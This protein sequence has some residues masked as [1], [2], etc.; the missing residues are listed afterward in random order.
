MKPSNEISYSL[1]TSCHDVHSN[2][3]SKLYY[4][5]QFPHYKFPVPTFRT[6]VVIADPFLDS[7]GSLRHVSKEMWLDKQ[8]NVWLQRHQDASEYKGGRLCHTS[9]TPAPW[10][11]FTAVYNVYTEAA[12]YGWMS[13]GTYKHTTTT[14]GNYTEPQTAKILWPNLKLTLPCR[15]SLPEKTVPRLF[16][17]LSA[18]T[19]GQCSRCMKKPQSVKWIFSKHYR[20]CFQMA[21]LL[22]FSSFLLK[23]PLKLYGHTV[24]C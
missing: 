12:V 6:P 1:L 7:T 20:S 22:P 4:S 16:S 9:S 8:W 24:L 23:L 15:P 13:Y 10:S 21:D 3:H 18:M 5:E 11:N 2:C 14:T 17:M 19:M